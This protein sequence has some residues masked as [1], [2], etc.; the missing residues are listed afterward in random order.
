MN[1]TSALIT[2][3]TNP[4]AGGQVPS[5][6]MTPPVGP[7]SPFTRAS[8][9]HVEPYLDWSSVITDSVQV[10]GGQPVD[11]P[12]YGYMRSTVLDVTASGGT[13][14]AAVYR[15]D[16]PWTVIQ[17]LSVLDV[18]G[19]TIIGPLSGYSVYLMQKWGGFAFMA[20][21]T[22]LVD[23]TAP[24]T[25]GN[26]RFQVRI[27]HQI[28]ERDGLGSLPNM[29]ASQTYKL[30]ISLAPRTDVYSANPTGTPT[31]RFRASLE[32]WA[33][34]SPTDA[35][36]GL[37]AVK[38]PNMG[39]TQFWS[40]ASVTVAA[41][42]QTVRFPKVGNLIRTFI[43]VFRDTTGARV[44][45]ANS[46]DPL[47]IF[48]D[49]QQIEQASQ[50]VRKLYMSE[51]TGY[52]TA[53]DD[54]VFVY[55]MTHDLTGKIGDELRDLWFRTAQSTRLELQASLPVAGSVTIITNDVAPQGNVFV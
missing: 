33:Q 34:P 36:G 25:A 13:G 9:E 50:W 37:N 39:T 21:P 30:R 49:G 41:G 16:A 35:A 46:P 32:A 43:L 8:M 48:W 26:F 1:A 29:N 55:D 12:A 14:A 24:T 22:L 28:S 11:I 23:Y 15:A 27:P 17:E 31:I 45:F 42:Q 20:N 2:G 51:R 10:V 38:P 7:M 6:S 4:G 3:P 18:N 47:A 54:G 53:L 19:T 44:T 40:Q 52:V 5:Q